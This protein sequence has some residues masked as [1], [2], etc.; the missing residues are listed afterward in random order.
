MKKRF[1][2]LIVM[3]SMIL[4]VLPAAG[5]FADTDAGS[6]GPSASENTVPGEIEGEYVPNRVLVMYESGAVDTDRPEAS[7]GELRALAG[8]EHRSDSFGLSAKSVGDD[9]A[10][11]AENTLGQ[12]V[13]IL[14]ESIS[15]YAIDD[16]VV[17]ASGRKSPEMVISTISS[18]SMNTE[19]MIA[20][21][22]GNEKIKY[23]EPDYV[24]RANSLPDWDDPY[25]SEMYHLFDENGIHADTLWEL[26]EYAESLE[27]NRTEDVLVAV[28]D[29][30]VDYTHPDL[31]NRMWVKPETRAFA[32]FIG[33]YGYDFIDYS[34]DPMDENNHGTHCAGII[35][36]Q[37]NNAAG[38]T[39]VAGI[40][41]KVKI[42][43]VRCLGANG[44]GSNS[45]LIAGM[46]YVT[47]LKKAGANVRAMNCSFGGNGYS[48]IYSEII[49][50]AGKEGILTFVAAGNDRTDIDEVPA[51]PANSDSNY[52]ITVVASDADGSVASYSNYGYTK[53]DVVAPGSNILSTVCKDSFT[54]F[55]YDAETIRGYADPEGREY[56]GNTEYYGEF[57]GA[58]IERVI[59]IQGEEVD[60]VKPVAGTDYYGNVIN[61]EKDPR[62]QVREFGRSVMLS[63]RIDGSEGTASLAISDQNG[64]GIGGNDHHL[65]WKITNAK[66]GDVYLLYFP[67]EKTAGDNSTNYVSMVYHSYHPEKG[68]SDGMFQV[69][70]VI[71]NGIDRY[72]R[73]D[74]TDVLRDLYGDD[75]T[76]NSVAANSVW[77]AVPR[78]NAMYPYSF[79]G[80]IPVSGPVYAVPEGNPE[81]K[82]VQ[83]SAAG[84]GLGVVYQAINDG[85]W[86]FDISSLAI[87]KADADPAS[88]GK[89]GVLSG[90]SMA[91][92]VAAGAAAILSVMN[93]EMS[94]KELKTTLLTATD[95][96]YKGW[97]ST[98]GRIDLSQ[99]TLPAES[100]KPMITN[101]AA[102]F[103]NST[104]TLYGENFGTAPVVKIKDLFSGRTETIPVNDLRLEDGAIV[105]G[106]AGARVSD[107][108]TLNHGIIGSY[109]CFE[110]ENTQNGRSCSCHS[111]VVNGLSPYEKAFA[112]N[113][114]AVVWSSSQGDEQ[115]TL[116]ELEFIPGADELLMADAVGNIYVIEH[117][118]KADAWTVRSVGKTVP[119]IIYNYLQNKS[120]K[121]GPWQDI[122]QAVSQYQFYPLG[123]P[124][125]MGGV[126][127]EL[128]RVVLGYRS[129]VLLLGLNL[130]DASWAM[131]SDSLEEPEAIPE[132]L[133]WNAI[134]S[135]TLAGYKGRLYLFGAIRNK[136]FYAGDDQA[137]D[138]AEEDILTR[139]FSC[140]PAQIDGKIT[141]W[142][143]EN[144]GMAAPRAN[145][146][147]ITQGGNL[148]YVLS[149]GSST[150][151]DY[152][153][154]RFNGSK[155]SAAGTL[156]KALYTD[157]KGGRSIRY[158]NRESLITPT[159]AGISCSIGIDD[160]GILFG[161]KSFHQ[162]GDTFRF[163]T[164]TGKT[165]PLGR[166]LWGSLSSARALG[167]VAGGFFLAGFSGNSGSFTEKCFE[168]SDDYVT[169]RKDVSG[170]GKGTVSGVWSYSRGDASK[171]YII[172][173][174]RS[175]IMS[176]VSAGTGDD[177]ELK[178]ITD[179]YAR[180]VLARQAPVKVNYNAMDNAVIKVV[181]GKISTKINLKSEVSIVYGTY[182]LDIKTDGTINGVDLTSSN[183]SYA[184]VNKDGSVTFKAAGIGKTVTITA[185]A[186]DDPSVRAKCVVTIQKKSL[187]KAVMTGIKNEVYTG[188]LIKPVPTVTLGSVTLRPGTD[189]TVSY[190]NNRKAGKATVTVTG[191]GKY[192]GKTSVKFTIKKAKNPVSVTAA[193]KWTSFEKLKKSSVTG[194]A[195]AVKK[196][197]GEVTY[198]K[199]SGASNLS[200][201][202]KTGKITIKK[203]TKK[204]TYKIRVAVT[205]AGDENYS[206]ATAKVTV[207][208]LVK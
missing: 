46:R 56:P 13:K 94:A 2:S 180:N 36:A 139:V 197:R 177:I 200:V 167:T 93:P 159:Y 199:V 207:K 41:D 109:I 99:Y 106:H 195:I 49:E 21:L 125:C 183:K 101:A 95:D 100:K 28:V 205:A 171:A 80:N 9:A 39:G 52:R 84:Y 86:Y 141:V 78:S 176:A 128:V 189:Y 68:G 111:Y 40:S 163:N 143:M 4:C 192:T 12:Q 187:A 5:V 62:H 70:D 129:A 61:D 118:K 58:K 157:T 73:V 71:I 201:N 208:I 150:E 88:F 85:D 30:G 184:V 146:V 123:N 53:T 18:D 140:E 87:A 204:G 110:A 206:S 50:E 54:P 154:Y 151:I 135:A 89:Y 133:S 137:Q 69:G 34:H 166:S 97:C 11:A 32:G 79:I 38:V 174:E 43:A 198:K 51:S 138:Y 3:L 10:Q 19:Q 194:S 82:P 108:D 90:T 60:A 74:W 105:I 44:S 1:L 31:R 158:N 117:N 59:N 42:I 179:D 81:G 67:Y 149:T 27:N 114:K 115:T 162:V 96:L 147:P 134:H 16:T 98:G 15:D 107:D 113:S 121:D 76:K 168:I 17:F 182:D 202:A 161:G 178:A 188:K 72:G 7:A 25:L 126:V 112:F 91:T 119:D 203:G 57:G 186:K 136:E 23:V 24:I 173:N 14:D 172:P 45:G 196:A 20:A 165:E 145:G 77:R 104:V 148:Y 8:R 103:E 22:K 47:A 124:V 64:F 153:V 66:A 29:T 132:E 142:R 181:F 156:P 131:Y 37:A 193:S 48:Q 190:S 55:L 164:S 160:Q 127:Y 65:T 175:Y 35:A 122:I 191:K 169:L 116:D 6:P 102:D 75:A 83:T 152:T 92:P 144:A 170:D 33:K 120:S 26:P 185:A 63:N 130:N 155:W